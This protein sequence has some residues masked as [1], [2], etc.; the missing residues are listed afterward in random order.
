[1]AKSKPNPN[2]RPKVKPA[3]ASATVAKPTVT[4]AEGGPSRNSPKNFPEYWFIPILVGIAFLVNASTINYGY[5]L[6]DPFFTKDNPMVNKGISAIP[7]FFTHAAYYGVFK[8]HDASY[9]PL[10]LTSFAVEKEFFGFNPKVSHFVNLV[11]FC[12]QVAFLFVLLRRVFNKYSAFI[13]FFIVLLFELHPIHT[14]VVASIKSR[15]EIL[16]LLLTALCTL[17]SFKF[18]DTGK[19]KHLILSGIYF[20]LALMGKETPITFVAIVPVTIYFFRDVPIRKIVITCIP[21]LV[22]AAI[23][24]MM[25]AAFI[26]SD[27]EKVRILVNNNA[28]MAA[29]NYGDKLATALFIQLKYILLL[30]YPHPLSYDYSYNQIP[31]IPLSN[32]KALAAIAV[33]GGLLGYALTHLKRKDVFSYCILFYFGSVALTSNILVDIGATMAERFVYTASLGFCIGIV[34]L[35]TKFLKADNRQLSYATAPKVFYILIPIALLYSAKTIARNPD[36]NSNLTLYESGYE[37][38]PDS[39]RANNL[40]GVT[41]TKMISS[42]TNPVEKQNLF[43]KAIFHFNRSIAIMPGNAEVWLLKGYAFDFIGNHNDS[44]ILSYK[45]ALVLDSNNHEAINNL[46]AVYLKMADFGDAIKVLTRAVAKDTVHTDA[47]ANL[48][49]A[50][51]NS[52][53]LKEAEKY[54]LMAIR[55]KADQPANVWQSMS[56]IYH[57]M[58]DSAKAQYYRKILY[59]RGK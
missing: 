3:G 58:G 44:A 42:E 49:A 46:G 2:S 35:V 38:A 33:I 1:M 47:I 16:A 37:T 22:V 39:W 20:F 18:V 53:N 9:R 28:L 24:M 45:N 56:N 5:T 4:H 29:T 15:D 8:N 27:G 55:I 11:L 13:P 43:N 50:Y 25:R 32:I 57:Y 6:D 40:L 52:G 23:Y 19:H 7:E 17:Q 31:I 48:A 51:G 30:I 26:E 12:L 21:Y 14:E 54:Y 34:F 10:L 59:G 41:Y 36:W